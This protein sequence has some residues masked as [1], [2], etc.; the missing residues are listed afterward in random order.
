V[1]SFE[2]QALSAHVA[3]ADLRFHNPQPCTAACCETTDS[4]LMHR[5]VWLFMSELSPVP[6]YTAWWQRHIGVNNFTKVVTRQRGGR[7]SNSR[8]LSH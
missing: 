1:K 3:S 5:L 7:A 6:S 4:R 2:S 8:P